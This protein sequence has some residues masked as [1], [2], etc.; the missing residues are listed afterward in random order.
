MRQRQI[1]VIADHRPDHETHIATDGALAHAAD[2][3]GLELAVTW[4]ATDTLTGD[5]AEKLASFDGLLIAPGSPYRSM[6]GA[7]DAIAYA[8]SSGVPILGTCGGFQHMVIEYARNVADSTNV[9]HAEYD[10]A[11]TDPLIAELSCSL[12]GRTMDVSIHPD[13]I[14]WNAYGTSTTTEPYYCSFGINPRRRAELEATGLVV[15]GTDQ[16]GEIR[17]IELDDHVFYLA[18]LFVP[19]INSTPT[20]PH[21]IVLA[22]LHAVGDSR[23]H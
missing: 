3:L 13:S 5:V 21:P 1:A 10:P 17:I 4:V 12:A 23:P 22:F 9:A 6:Q 8:R 20:A 18:T 2:S 7:I 11:A 14:A 15:S 19:Q 16:D